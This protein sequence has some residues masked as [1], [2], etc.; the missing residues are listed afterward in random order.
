MVGYFCSAQ[1]KVPH[2]VKQRAIA[3][4]ASEYNLRALVETGTNL[5]NTINVRKSSFREIHLIELNEWLAS[6]AKQKFRNE[7]N[8]H[9]YQGDSGKVLPKILEQIDEPC[10]FWLDA[11]WATESMSA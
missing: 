1:P 9:L 2:L 8:V 5:G 3:Q 6:R 10:L 11:H 7:P 4:F